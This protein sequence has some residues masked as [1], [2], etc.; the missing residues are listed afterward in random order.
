MDGIRHEILVSY[1]MLVFLIGLAT[2]LILRRLHQMGTTS[3]AALQQI[4]DKLDKAL[5]S[6]A[7]AKTASDTIIADVEKLLA[8]A[9]GG[10][11]VDPAQL[12]AV[13]DKVQALSDGL[14][15]ETAAETAE[16][17]KVPKP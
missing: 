15:T 8:A 3:Q 1:L 11:S 13:L 7:A 17:A 16:D 12:Q 10:Q 14:D 4:S 9:Q 2:I 6:Q 5:A